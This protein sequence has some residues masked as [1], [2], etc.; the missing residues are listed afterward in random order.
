MKQENVI[1]I[2][3]WMREKN[4]SILIETRDD[5]LDTLDE[6][7]NALKNKLK[8]IEDAKTRLRSI[9]LKTTSRKSLEIQL[10]TIHIIEELLLLR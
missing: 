2:E 6:A 7:E 8:I 5:L 4:E 1:S 10:T 3:N 9:D